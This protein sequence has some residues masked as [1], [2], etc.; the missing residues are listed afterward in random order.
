MAA[1]EQTV[2]MTTD[3]G[4]G[5]PEPSG[6]FRSYRRPVLQNGLSDPLPGRGIRVDGLIR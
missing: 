5:Q 4:S 2:Q 3:R 6:E 1:V